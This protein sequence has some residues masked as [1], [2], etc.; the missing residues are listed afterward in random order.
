MLPRL[1]SIVQSIN[2]LFVYIVDEDIKKVYEAT[3]KL[4]ANWYILGLALK[5]E[6]FN[7]D[8]IKADCREVLPCLYKMLQTWIHTRSATWK[9]LVKAIADPAYVNNKKL[10]NEIYKNYTQ[11]ISELLCLL[12]VL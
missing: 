6:D 3:Y 12:R 5:I 9:N 8:R 11:H 4:S 2:V 1:Y 7:L 10:A